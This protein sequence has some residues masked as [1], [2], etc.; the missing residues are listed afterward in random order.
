[1]ILPR[2]NTK[3]HENTN[4]LFYFFYPMLFKFFIVIKKDKAENEL[5]AIE[6]E[7]EVEK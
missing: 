2:T 7:N 1:M 3:F 6:V 5:P 4:N